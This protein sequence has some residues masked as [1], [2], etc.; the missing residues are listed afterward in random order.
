MIGEHAV[1]AKLEGL[2]PEQIVGLP[3]GSVAGLDGLESMELLYPAAAVLP[4]S[5]TAAAAAVR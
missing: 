4:G 2:L 1:E 3:G 5:L